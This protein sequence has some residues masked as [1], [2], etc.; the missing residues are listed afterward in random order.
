MYN[1]DAK[2]FSMELQGKYGIAK[3]F[4][5]CIEQEAIA[6]ILTILN[7]PM[8]EGVKVRIMP[9]VHAGAG[10]VIGYTATLNDYIVPN[11]IGVDIGCGLAA[12]TF[13]NDVSYPDL[14]RFIRENIP[15][16]MEVNVSCDPEEIKT[17]LSTFS[18][19]PYE[20]FHDEVTAISKRIGAD[21][22]RVLRGIGSLGGGN[23][24]L[25]V[26]LDGAKYNHLV[27]HSGSRNFGKR[28]AEWHQ[29]EAALALTPEEMKAAIINI[30]ENTPRQDIEKAI[31]E[32]RNNLPRKV[33]NLEYLEGKASEAYFFDMKIAQL[34][35]RLNRRVILYRIAGFLEVP[36]HETRLIE[37]VHNYINFEDGI[38]RKGAI[39][40]HKGER[41]LIPLSMADG[42]LECEGN[43]NPEWN[44]SAP[45]GAGR[46]MSR[47]KARAAISM[48][49]YKNRMEEAGVWT[50]C[51]SEGTLDEAPQ[52]YKN[53][54]TII[55]AIGDTV[56][57]V[58]QWREVYNFKAN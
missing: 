7:Q 57:I 34:Y 48:D 58:D 25:S 45:H 14:D 31:R 32:F 56:N 22:D 47:G 35:A 5:D 43:G 3:V 37:S 17:V 52:A 42:I 23:H 2:E 54:A 38:I 12:C 30:R 29:K 20:E 26:N 41:C 49:D 39:S 9:D 16:G 4:T 6:Q 50:S 11:F 53:P 40:A 44:Q 27:V 15:Y 1:A 51:V 21:V 24:F 33:K 8:M 46:L 13:Y 19:M 36:Y 10:I 55:E 28:I 18:S